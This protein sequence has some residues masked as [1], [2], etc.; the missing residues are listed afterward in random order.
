M[1]T[2][3]TCIA[4]LQS[5]P[6]ISWPVAGA[7]RKTPS[8]S[9]YFSWINHTNEGPSYEQTMANLEFFRWLHDEYGMRL[10]IYAFDAGAIDGANMYGSMDSDKFKKQFPYG[11]GPVAEYAAEMDTRLGIW[12][13][14]DGFGNTDGEARDRIE[15]MESLC[16]DYNFKLFKLDGVCGPL[17]KEKYDYFDT[18]MTRCRKYS[19]DLIM[20]NHRLDLGPGTRHSTTFLLGGAETYIDVHMTN[21]TTGTHHRVGAMSRSLPENLIRLT[22]DHGVCLSSCLDYWEDDLILQAFN[23]NLI[24]SPQIY[25]NPWLLRDDE[26]PK[27]AYIFN[28]HRLYRDI[29]VDAVL[30]PE[31][32]GKDAVSRGSGKTRFITLKNLE[33][34]PKKVRLVLDESAGLAKASKYR[35]RRYHPYQEDLGEYSYG[36]CVEIEVMPF[37]AALIKVTSETERD[38]VLVS[39]APYQ[40]VKDHGGLAKI[41]IFGEAGTEK[42]IVVEKSG[43]KKIFRV[44]FEGQKY[45]NVHYKIGTAVE[46]PVPDDI[47]SIYYATCFA[48]DNNALEV[49]SLYRSGATEIPQVEKARN[50]FFGQKMFVTRDCWDKYMFDGDHSTAFSICMRWG[51]QRNGTS[52]FCLD[53]GE[54]ILIDELQLDSYDEYSIAPLKSGE[55]ADAFVSADMKDWK[56][57]KFETGTRMKIDLEGCG[58]VR[59]LRFSPCPLRI[60]EVTGF[61]RGKELD[62]SLWRASNLF[63]PYGAD[64]YS[65]KK[66]FKKEFMLDDFMP[67]SYLCIAVNGLHGVD[68]V[69]AGCRI[70][71]EYAGCPDRAP[72]FTSNVWEFR[73]AKSDR[74]NTFF[75]PLDNRYKGEKIEVYVM[76]MDAA[77]TDFEPEIW[78]T[79]GNLP[80]EYE[81]IE[82]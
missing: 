40:I 61:Y 21:E 15:M 82:F 38:N 63:R 22:E 12:G 33:W 53:F 7:D 23:R 19:P 72:S 54:Q 8:S 48:A 75:L 67:G 81:I 2:L 55:G 29:L 73:S 41:K 46:S 47:S 35:I 27:L 18:L 5:F 9:E 64:G 17:R 11:F 28:L 52:G 36:A 76:A 45:G 49:R 56:S 30:L 60:C 34:E 14:P 74:N 39:G 31:S 32:C 80:F 59:Y 66:V 50:T 70:G 68:G 25:G 51:D 16:R 69:W 10:D 57:V 44:R 3:I 43:K 24:V 65:A 37:R 4:L 58:P 20:L 79:S 77:H 42:R 1:V 62:R 13:G 78:I 6:G 71:G 26:F